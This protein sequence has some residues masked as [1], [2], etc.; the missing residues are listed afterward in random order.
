ML[1]R[2]KHLIYGV[3]SILTAIISG[4]VFSKY[5]LGLGTP[6]LIIRH[7]KIEYMYKPNQDVF[8]FGNR[9]V[10][11]QYGMRTMQFERNKGH[12]EFRVMVFGDSVINGGALTD[13]KD[14][15]TT[16]LKESVNNKNVVVGNISAGSWGPGNWLAYA[17]EYGFFGA[18]VIIL[19]ISS[20]DYSDNPTFQPLNENTHPTEKPVSALVE[21]IVRYLPRYIHLSVGKQNE[22]EADKFSVEVSIKEV[23]RG[24]G[25]LR[26]FLQ[27][28]KSSSEKVLV[29]QN[30]EKSEIVSGVA[31]TG[32]KRIN[33]ICN[34]LE[35]PCISL[36]PYFKNSIESGDDP[37][38]DNIH[39]NQIGQKIISNA[40]FE[41][42][43]EPA[44]VFS[45]QP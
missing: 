29:F 11:N 34:Q 36:Y 9:F 17:E 35:V 13:H 2:K 37:Y 14:L 28:A 23:E 7:P 8:R 32:N 30:W 16:T 33:I 27:L 12:G 39:P 31:N 21:G 42:I 1:I 6:P 18:D 4:E 25:D 26:K 45:G 22:I 38:R 24:I 10:V 44:N 41:N 15:A 43:R 19:V 20:H 5:Y 40:M 3:F